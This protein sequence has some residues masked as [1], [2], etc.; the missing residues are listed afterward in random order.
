MGM[1]PLE[2]KYY[3]QKKLEEAKIFV[4][5]NKPLFALQICISL[6]N[7]I[8]DCYLAYFNAAEICRML[9][10]IPAAVDLL[11]SCIE[12]LPENNELRYD[13]GSF[14]IQYKCWKDAIN[15]FS[16][17]SIEEEPMAAYYLG[18]AYYMENDYEISLHYFFRFLKYNIEQN[19]VTNSYLFISKIY[20]KNSDFGNALTY[21]KKAESIVSYDWEV[22]L[23]LAQAY[24]GLG[25]FVHAQDPIVKAIDLMPN[26]PAC[27]LVAGNIFYHNS[28]FGKS[29]F[30]LL[31]YF[32]TANEVLQ[33]SYLLFADVLFMLKKYSESLAYFD[34][35]LSY[36]PQDEVAKIKKLDALNAYNSEITIKENISM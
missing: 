1:N 31:K 30:Y 10:N 16:S 23:I 3:T 2:T 32:E 20:L 8:P 33:S 15:I 13:A 28:D 22:N 21:I 7:K 36:N 26:E 11:N 17:M 9:G 5:N 6:I 25:M 24:S 27:C 12:V 19:F 35:Y 14:M 18:Y 29:E 34:L 4:D